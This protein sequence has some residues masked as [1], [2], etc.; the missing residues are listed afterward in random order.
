M[1]PYYKLHVKWAS[2]RANV[3]TACLA[4]KLL[5]CSVRFP[6]IASILLDSFVLFISVEIFGVYSTTISNCHCCEK[7][8]DRVKSSWK[9]PKTE[10]IKT[11]ETNNYGFY[12]RNSWYLLN[13]NKPFSLILV[14]FP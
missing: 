2:S 5:L 11:E 8:L 7:L 12:M 6:A 4:M 13:M 10:F 1:L 9:F 3:F 14:S